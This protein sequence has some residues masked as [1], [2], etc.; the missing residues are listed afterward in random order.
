MNKESSFMQ[1]SNMKN[2]LKHYKDT[3]AERRKRVQIIDGILISCNEQE[4]KRFIDELDDT[5]IHR[6]IGD[7]DFEST[8]SSLDKMIAYDIYSMI[9]PSALRRLTEMAAAPSPDPFRS[10][11][12]QP[13]IL[14]PKQR[15]RT[16]AYSQSG[17]EMAAVP[18]EEPFEGPFWSKEMEQFISKP[19]QRH[20]TAAY[21]QSGPEMA[22]VPSPVPFRS[23]QMQPFIPEPKQRHRTAAYS[24]SGPEM[25]AVPDEEPFEG[26]FWSK[27]MEQFLSEQS[28]VQHLL[29]VLKDRNTSDYVKK[30]Y[31]EN[32]TD[33]AI[34]DI[35]RET[36]GEKFSFGDVPNARKQLLAILNTH[37]GYN[38]NTSVWFNHCF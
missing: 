32:L 16:A 5:N 20:Q 24:Q 30:I 3:P 2:L 18:D 10:K 33:E 12:M 27:E 38:Y 29:N 25:A 23:K 34:F 1:I 26:P 8:G 11:Q 31:I 35:F 9:K 17:P 37:G 19:K 13:F 22:A 28:Q 14:E 6:L 36:Y 21:S 7:F 4:W 15:H